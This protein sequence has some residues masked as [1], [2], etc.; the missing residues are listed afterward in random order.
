[1]R[2]E[3]PRKAPPIQR[4]R[5][6]CMSAP[7]LLADTRTGERLQASA[8]TASQDTWP[9]VDLRAVPSPARSP[10]ARRAAVDPAT[11]S[12]FAGS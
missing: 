10:V 8:I 9:P 6:L 7:V 2:S 3:I 1:V 5:V 4:V 11:A 12:R